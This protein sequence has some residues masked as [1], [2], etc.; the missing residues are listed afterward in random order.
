MGEREERVLLFSGWTDGKAE[1][2]GEG[3][4]PSLSLDHN[5][6]RRPASLAPPLALSLARRTPRATSRFP[7]PTRPGHRHTAPPRSLCVQRGSECRGPPASAPGR[8]F[9]FF[10]SAQIKKKKKG[11][12]CRPLPATSSSRRSSPPSARSSASSCTWHPPGRCWRPDG[13]GAWGYVGREKERGGG[14]VRAMARAAAHTAGRL[15]AENPLRSSSFLSLSFLSLPHAS[16]QDLNPI[17][18]VSMLANA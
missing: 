15:E 16:L 3:R 4:L 17:P 7:T 1:R 5:R 2:E 6:P 8:L 18:M 14:H 10:S 13:G 9:L 12:K 11:K